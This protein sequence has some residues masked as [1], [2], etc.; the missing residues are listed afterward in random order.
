MCAFE[1]Y[2]QEFIH[3]FQPSVAYLKENVRTIVSEK[4]QC[5]NAMKIAHPWES[6]KAYGSYVMYEHL[7][8]I[9]P[10]YIKELRYCQWPIEFQWDHVIPPA[11]RSDA[12]VQIQKVILIQTQDK[13]KCYVTFSILHIEWNPH[14][15][16]ILEWVDL[17]VKLREILNGGNLTH[18]LLI[19]GQWN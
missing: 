16:L 18:R 6:Q 19:W 4:H 1:A 15:W 14:S 11:V 2:A 12:L 9:F 3:K 10:L 7:P 8:E 17:K 13:L 5:S